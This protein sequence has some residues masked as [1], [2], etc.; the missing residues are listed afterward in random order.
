MPQLDAFGKSL[1]I[2]WKH[3]EPGTEAILIAAQIEFQQCV[4][5]YRGAI[6]K[7]SYRR[8]DGFIN[9][10]GR[11][12]EQFRRIIRGDA[13]LQLCDLAEAQLHFGDSLNLNV[14]V[15]GGARVGP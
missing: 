15:L 6:D 5:I 1:H 4:D 2:G 9:T 14:P 13:V 12:Y 10:I 7:Y 8:L 11:P 3:V